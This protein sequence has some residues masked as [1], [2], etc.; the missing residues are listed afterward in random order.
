M[1]KSKSLNIA[2]DIIIEEIAKSEINNQDKVELMLNIREFL[3]PKNYKENIYVLEK[4]YEN[5]R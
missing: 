2:L 3:E 5:K 1:M 4:H